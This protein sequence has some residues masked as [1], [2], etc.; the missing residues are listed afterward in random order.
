MS[1][2]F[3]AF[4]PSSVT[5][6]RASAGLLSL[7]GAFVLGAVWPAAQTQPP[8]SDLVVG[9][10]VNMVS[11]QQLPDGDPY[12]QRQNEPSVAASTRNPLH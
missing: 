3:P 6:I 8:A 1:Q 10:N 4:L 11:G 5:R 2:R 9:R 7:I 12:L